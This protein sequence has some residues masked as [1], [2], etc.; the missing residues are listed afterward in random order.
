MNEIEALI[1]WRAAKM[2]ES[3]GVG[4]QVVH[5]HGAASQLSAEL[6]SARDRLI[7]HPGEI[8][9]VLAAIFASEGATSDIVEPIQHGPELADDIR[10]LVIAARTVAYGDA[11]PEAIQELD[12]AAEAFSELVPW[13][14]EPTD[15]AMSNPDGEPATAEGAAAEPES[16]QAPA[17]ETPDTEA[18]ADE[19]GT[20]ADA[21]EAPAVEAPA[22]A[23]TEQA[24]AKKPRSAK[25]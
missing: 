8:A 4:V 5:V 22:D 13:E 15:E 11:D 9:D 3:D 6:G 2:A 19:A 21:G 23:P 10:R 17:A 24:Q 12:A 20:P 7:S 25:Q 16:D 1:V 18:V 14:D